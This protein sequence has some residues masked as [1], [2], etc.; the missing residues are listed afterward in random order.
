[1]GMRG[2]IYDWGHIPM[3]LCVYGVAGVITLPGVKYKRRWVEI[4]LK[5]CKSAL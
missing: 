5:I 3:C 4:R 2:V 1:M